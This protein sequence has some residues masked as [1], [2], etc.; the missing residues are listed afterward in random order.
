M[1]GSTNDTQELSFWQVIFLQSKVNGAPYHGEELPQHQWD[2]PH[3]TYLQS[4]LRH[5]RDKVEIANLA[6]LNQSAQARF[7]RFYK[8]LLEYS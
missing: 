8:R 4:R 7:E 5:L 2:W 1:T 3:E 6:P